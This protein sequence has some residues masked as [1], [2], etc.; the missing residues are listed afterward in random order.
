M[1]ISSNADKVLVGN[2]LFRSNLLIILEFYIHLESSY[3]PEIINY[4][5][6]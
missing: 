5:E 2:K 4:E 3:L 1:A 6:F